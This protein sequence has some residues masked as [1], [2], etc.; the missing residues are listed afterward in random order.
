MD[1]LSKSYLFSTCFTLS[2]PF[3]SFSLS[4]KRYPS[5]H[6]RLIPLGLT[7][8]N[9]IRFLV[10]LRY[11]Q[12]IIFCNSLFHSVFLFA[13]SCAFV[14]MFVRLYAYSIKCLSISLLIYLF[15]FE[16]YNNKCGQLS[17]QNQKI[18]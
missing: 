15:L 9:F 14:R 6:S 13:S 1:G 8:P 10:L 17:T 7:L 12:S 5:F 11:D 3:R 18:Y 4:S 2:F 16:M